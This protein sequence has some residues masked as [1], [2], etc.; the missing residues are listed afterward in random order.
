MM[1]HSES[2]LKKMN[3]KDKKW[4]K[5]QLYKIWIEDNDNDRQADDINEFLMELA[6]MVE[7]DYMKVVE[8]IRK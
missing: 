6:G 1:K 7:F 4:I 3:S 2:I 8:D 5:E